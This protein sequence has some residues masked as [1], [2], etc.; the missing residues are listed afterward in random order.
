MIWHTYRRGFQAGDGDP[1]RV[2]DAKVYGQCNRQV[3][4]ASQGT[5]W[6]SLIFMFS[7]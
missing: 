2:I 5:R 3:R 6:L 4:L 7:G 1:S